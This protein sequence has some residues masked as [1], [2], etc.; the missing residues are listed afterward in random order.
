MVAVYYILFRATST[1]IGKK[2]VVEIEMKYW[3]THKNMFLLLKNG[4]THMSHMY[5]RSICHQE[6]IIMAWRWVHTAYINQ[7]KNIDCRSVIIPDTASDVLPFSDSL[8]YR[9]VHCM[10]ISIYKHFRLVPFD[11]TIQNMSS[12]TFKS[13]R[14]LRPLHSSCNQSGYHTHTSNYNLSK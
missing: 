12:L 13:N 5:K 7:N 6:D 11:R 2:S 14:T 1:T 8:L 9:H 3:C 4:L 10:L